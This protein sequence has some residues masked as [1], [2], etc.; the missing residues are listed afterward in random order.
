MPAKA[1]DRSVMVG[2]AQ[3]GVETSN[4]VLDVIEATLADCEFANL[5]EWGVGILAPEKSLCQ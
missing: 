3:A 4:E 2:R 5:L 1:G